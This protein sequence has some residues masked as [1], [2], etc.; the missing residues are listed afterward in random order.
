MKTV[1]RRSALLFGILVALSLSPVALICNDSA[2]DCLNNS[3]DPKAANNDRLTCDALKAQGAKFAALNALAQKYLGDAGLGDLLRSER[4]LVAAAVVGKSVWVGESSNPKYCGNDPGQVW[5]Q[6]PDRTIRAQVLAWMLTDPDA[7]KLRTHR[8][9]AIGGAVVRGTLDLRNAGDL[10]VLTLNNCQLG[11]IYLS[12]AVAGTI[13]L[14]GSKIGSLDGTRVQIKGDLDLVK[15]SASGEIDLTGANIN[16][17][18]H[19]GN[20]HLRYKGDSLILASAT[21]GE[22]AFFGGAYPE[23]MI[24]ATGATIKRDMDFSDVVFG[25]SCANGLKAGYATVRGNFWWAPSIIGQHTELDLVGA[26]VG[27]LHFYQDQKGWPHQNC[28]FLDGFEFQRLA[29]DS[30]TDEPTL[31]K[32]LARSSAG[33]SS[34]CA[35]L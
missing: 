17:S 32:W 30:P 2:A 10:A 12:D 16:G 5:P 31:K 14:S 24:R 28:L 1:L 15:V 18:L 35:I 20:A 29:P 33:P 25:D 26:W 6:S 13:D 3:A 9:I 11:D 22:S 23:G 27:S 4:C 7:K 19:A 21:V 8:E 34:R